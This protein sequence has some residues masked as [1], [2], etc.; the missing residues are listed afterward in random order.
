[1]T[2]DIR[3][4]PAFLTIARVLQA[5]RTVTTRKQCLAC[6]AALKHLEALT[7]DDPQLDWVSKEAARLLAGGILSLRRNLPVLAADLVSLS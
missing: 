5:N 3:Y 4:R 2:T 7:R 6:V 1:M